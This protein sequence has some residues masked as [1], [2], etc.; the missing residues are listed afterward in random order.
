MRKNKCRF[1]ELAVNTRCDAFL[2][3]NGE[4]PFEF[5]GHEEDLPAVIPHYRVNGRQEIDIYAQ[6][7]YHYVGECV[8]CLKL[9]CDD[10]TR[11]KMDYFLFWNDLTHDEWVIWTPTVMHIKHDIYPGFIPV[12]LPQTSQPSANKTDS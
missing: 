12:G 1:A 4:W 2:D 8:A 3:D 11:Q 10:F 5:H 9:V 7:V 6:G